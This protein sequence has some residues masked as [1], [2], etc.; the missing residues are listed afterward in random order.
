MKTVHRAYQDRGDDYERM[1]AFLIEDYRDRGW[2]IWTLGRLGDWKYG[3]WTEKKYIPCFLGD[4]AHLWFDAFGDLAGFVVSENGDGGFTV[5]V[6]RGGDFLYGEILRWTV[7]HWHGRG[8]LTTEI[9]KDQPG[10]HPALRKAGFS[11]DGVIAV[12]QKYLLS[13][14]CGDPVPLPAGYCVVDMDETPDFEG[15]RLLQINAF[16]NRN[17][18]TALDVLSYRYSRE[19][20]VYNPQ[21][22]LSI[23]DETG[24]HVAGCQAFVDARNGYAEV[25]RICTHSDYRRRGLAAAVVRACFARLAEHGLTHAYIT[26]Y[27]PGAQALYAKLGALDCASWTLYRRSAVKDQPAGND[28]TVRG[29]V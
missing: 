22:D 27:S 18:L 17:E 23:L 28:H 14:F 15:K 21:F 6:R 24:R 19:C 12:T 26:G 4:N 16:Q 5:F 11:T 20:P 3:V 1:W 7:E 2:F 29:S 10:V 8:D 13:E 9:H 25:E